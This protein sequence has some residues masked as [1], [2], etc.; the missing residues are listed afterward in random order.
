MIYL[1][2]F[3]KAIAD[4]EKKGE[5][6]NTKIWISGGPLD[7]KSFLDDI[8]SILHSFGRAIIWSKKKKRTQALSKR[9][10]YWE[11]STI[12][13]GKCNFATDSSIDNCIKKTPNKV[14]DFTQLFKWLEIFCQPSFKNS[15]KHLKKQLLP[16]NI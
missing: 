3:C 2:S 9:P 1:R 13:Y 12:H 16:Y 15:K 14:H 11:P 10:N 8:K 4:R 6:G 5:D 7:E